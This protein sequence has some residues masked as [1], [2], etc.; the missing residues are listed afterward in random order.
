MSTQTTGGGSTTSF[1]NTPQATDDLFTTGVSASTGAAMATLLGKSTGGTL[2][3]IFGL[4]RQDAARCVALSRRRM[5]VLWRSLV[6]A[7]ASARCRMGHHEISS[8]SR[9]QG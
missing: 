6:F 4:Q 5:K 9:R 7:F 3:Q 8:P 1:S 2:A